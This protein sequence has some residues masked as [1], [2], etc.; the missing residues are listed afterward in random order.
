MGV[1]VAAGDKNDRLHVHG[2]RRPLEGQP[3]W[4]RWMKSSVGVRNEDWKTAWVAKVDVAY[5]DCY[6]RS[7]KVYAIC[8]LDN[9]THK[10]SACAQERQRLE[11]LS[12][13]QA[14]YRG[15]S[16]EKVDP[17]VESLED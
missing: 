13:K 5:N 9:V 10:V 4:L 15:L 3:L 6:A 17:N 1:P 8:V 7:E 2:L 11:E 16:V 14:A 12:E